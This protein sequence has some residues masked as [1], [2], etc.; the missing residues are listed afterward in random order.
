MS[1]PRAV[2]PCSAHAVYLRSAPDRGGGGDVHSPG[3]VG[4]CGGD[5]HPFVETKANAAR[6]G[7]PWGGRRHIAVAL[8][9]AA[10]RAGSSVYF[11]SLDDMVRQL[12][13]SR[14]Q[15]CSALRRGLDHPY[16]EHDLQR[17]GQVFGDKSSPPP[18]SLPS[19]VTWTQPA[20]QRPPPRP[21]SWSGEHDHDAFTAFR[22]QPERRVMG[23]WVGPTQH[24]PRAHG[25]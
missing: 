23:P 22:S 15:A 9:A 17:M 5:L 14:Q 19:N 4:G 24:L 12:K 18:T 3:Q 2:T 21:A 1:L 25:C 6:L 11:T 8:S 7:P 13:P 20:L 10:C 16:L